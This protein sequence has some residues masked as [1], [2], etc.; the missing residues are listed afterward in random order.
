[1]DKQAINV[2]HRREFG[3]SM[4]RRDKLLASGFVG[5]VEGPEDLAENRKQYL[6]K[7]LG[8]KHGVD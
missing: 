2:S 1:M 4:Q 8:E 5:C 3:V 7:G 6:S